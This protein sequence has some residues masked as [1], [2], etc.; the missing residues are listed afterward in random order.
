MN[1]VDSAGRTW[2]VRE[3]RLLGRP[4]LLNRLNRDQELVP[5][6]KSVPPPRPRHRVQDVAVALLTPDGMALTI[7]LLPVF[8][9][10]TAVRLVGGAV[11]L[12]GR[13]LGLTKSRV[14]V[15]AHT[16]MGRHSVTVLAAAPRDAKKLIADIAAER[17]GATRSFH[18]DGLPA[19]VTVV[20]HRSVWQSSDQWRTS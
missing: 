3:R 11:L 12:V 13:L 7:V 9:L 16:V 19:G 14:E 5:A 6:P 18:P 1:V 15:I 8:L 2:S 20:E 4:W 17:T 10:E